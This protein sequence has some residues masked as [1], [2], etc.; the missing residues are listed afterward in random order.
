M[1][2]LSNYTFA[3]VP[4]SYRAITG[5]S[6]NFGD[7]S[8]AALTPPFPILFGNG[9]FDTLFVSS[10]GNV[11][12][13][14]HFTAYS[15]LS[16][17][18]SAIDTLV[19]P[20]WDDLYSIFGTGQNVFWAV[21]GTPPNRELVIEWRDVRHYSCLTDISATVKFQLVLFEGRRDL[22]FN[23]ADVVFGGGCS[24]G[25]Q[26]GS[27]T[28]GVQIGSTTG[29]Q[30]SYNIQSLSNS[31]SLLWS[32]PR[33]G[34][35]LTANRSGTGIGTVTSSPAG[36]QCG[37][38]C[39][40]SYAE[41]TVVALSAAPNPGSNF[42]GWSGGGCSGTGVCMVTVDA[43]TLITATFT[44]QSFRLTVGKDGTGSGTV[45]ST[46][47]GI[48]CGPDCIEDYVLGSVV[49]LTAAPSAGSTFAGWSGACSGTGPCAVS[50]MANQSVT[51]TFSTARLNVTAPNG[52]EIWPIRRSQIIQWNSN[53]IT[54]KVKIELSR[55][56]GLSW[57]PLVQKTA[58]DGLQSWRV[59]G[60]ATTQARIR[61]CTVSSSLIC[62]T[63]DANFTI[64]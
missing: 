37:S 3:S 30:F 59:K 1:H 31:Y 55:D 20:F 61:I 7:D 60:P 32:L 14:G 53:G 5:A 24:F 9:S 58:N 28:V 39:S 44:L 34:F 22:L 46:P 6:L 62:D 15:N 47:S 48:N 23:Y 18:T 4:F 42:D 17:P 13:S 25:D 38:D 26:G 12:F 54:G 29:T 43:N 11:N 21:I 64:R 35:T 19:A 51:A 56:G 52:G 36:I 50:M 63:S 57:V 40:E 2:V 16:I 41:S 49:T 8:Y 27:A 45:T 33:P 10:N